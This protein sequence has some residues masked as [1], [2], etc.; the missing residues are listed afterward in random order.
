MSI[1]EQLESPTFKVT[2]S[3]K[4]LI[5][6]IKE[7]I[8]DVFYKP[9]SQ[10]AK[11]SN[12]G[13]ATITRF[14]KKMKF[15]G[16]QDFKV[17]LAQEIS[18]SNKKNI[19]NKNIQNDEPAL[20]TAKKLLN[21]NITTLENT[22]EIINSVDVHDCAR[23]IINA[24]K[25]YFIGI[26][27]SGIIAQDSNYKFM[28]IGLN[29]VSFDSSHTMIMMSSIMEEGDLIV[30]ISHSGETEEIIKTVKLA[31]A[32]NAKIISIT[33][34][35]NSELKDISDVHL[36]YV[37]GETVLETGSISSK[38]AQFFI[39]DLVYTQVVKELSNEA[40]ERKIKTTNAIKLFKNE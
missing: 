18:S 13:E 6:Y 27:Y 17:T 9:I 15:N 35:K 2:K 36:S 39:I 19:I 21:S 30:A 20:D 38:L 28:R 40:I 7:N 24:K 22:V 3:D 12:I 4:L 5:A 33:E 31:R 32:N 34:N 16:L 37:S 25:V 1:L 11:E 14:V 23:L 8:E 26:G 10:I 29:C